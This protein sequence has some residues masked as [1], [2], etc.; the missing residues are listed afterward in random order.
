MVAIMLAVGLLGIGWASANDS[1]PDIPRWVA[2]ATMAIK[3]VAPLSQFQNQPNLLSNIDCTP[4]GYRTVI[5]STMHIGC[6]TQTAFG[7]IDSDNDTVIYNATDEAIPLLP[8]AGHDVLAP[9]PQAGALLDLNPALVSGVYISLYRDPLAFMHNQRN[10]LGQVTAKHLTAAPEL[11]LRGPDG[12]LLVINPQTLAFSDEGSW[13]VAEDVNGSFVRLNLASLNVLPFAPSYGSS[14]S[15][16]LLKSEVAI[17]PDGRFVAINNEAAG[18][19]KVYDLSSCQNQVVNNLSPLNC[20]SY[21]YRWFLAQHISGL[22]YITHVRFIN[23]GLISFEA[24]TGQGDIDGTYELAPMAN[25]NSLIGYLGM[26]DSYTSGEGAFD[27]RKDTD[28]DDNKCHLSINSYPLLLSHDLFGGDGHSVACSGAIIRDINDLNGSY[29]GQVKGVPSWQQLQATDQSLLDSVMANF[30]PGYVA[31]ERFV[32]QYQPNVA[33]V[34]IGGNDIGFGDILVKCVE[35]KVS[36]RPSAQNCFNTYE[37]RLELKNL[38]DRTMPRWTSLY[39]SLVAAA[40]SMRLYAIGYPQIASASGSCALNVHLSQ[41]EL[42]FTAEI[43]DYLDGDIRQAATGA[44]IP[45]IDISQALKGHRLCETASYDVAVNG[46]T[47]G[48]DKGVF[49]INILGKESYHPNAL[50]QHLIEQAILKQTNNFA[51]ATSGDTEPPDDSK[52]LNAPKS[53]RTIY[54]LVPQASLASTKAAA[55][56]AMSININ[57]NQAGL[58]SNT[59]YAVHLDGPD[60]TTAGSL[61]SDEYGDLDSSVILPAGT[62]PGEHSIDVIGTNQ[63][64]EPVDVTQPIYVPISDKNSDGDDIADSDDSCPYTVNSGIDSDRDSIDDTC[65]P[66]IGQPLTSSGS[67]DANN[68]TG[69]HSTPQGFSSARAFEG[70]TLSPDNDH[71]QKLSSASLKKLEPDFPLAKLRTFSWFSWVILPILAWWLIISIYLIISL[72]KWLKN[73][74]KMA[75]FLL[76]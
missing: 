31:Q 21:D 47:A 68:T 16:A 38:I 48:D 59:S 45:Y 40:P 55:G 42:E 49:G 25:I 18:V 57:G 37:S 29:R 44:G 14:G 2:P 36:L 20:P 73:N 53:G 5:D 72:I 3:R 19:F 71:L 7:Q 62:D 26:G 65:D 35:P 63:A 12:Q 24:H 74:V 41:S 33:T 11:Q 43:I 51:A 54:T 69:D 8:Y 61:T 66:L 46:L 15:P 17:S 4:I 30:L 76:Q 6:F 58:A 28:T 23:D 50:G 13:L 10:A 32:Q 22:E 60:G 67:T 9:W 39:Q 64:D 70:T 56:Q 27:Y 75:N 52:L 1:R 34:S